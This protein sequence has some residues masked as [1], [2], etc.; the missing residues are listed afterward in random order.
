VL[1]TNTPNT[2]GT[3]EV[4]V[5]NILCPEAPTPPDDPLAGKLVFRTVTPSLASWIPIV[6][7][8]VVLHDVDA[9]AMDRPF[10]ATFSG[11]AT[12]YIGFTRQGIKGTLKATIV[13]WRDPTDAL[14]PGIMLFD[15][16]EMTF[17][18]ENSPLPYPLEWRGI[19]WKGDLGRVRAPGAVNGCWVASCGACPQEAFCFGEYQGINIRL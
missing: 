2:A 16:V 17:V 19:V 13:D 15:T 11:P 6:P 10:A 9:Y 12:A 18:P 3:I 7:V 14:G 5:R 8:L 1:I 4:A